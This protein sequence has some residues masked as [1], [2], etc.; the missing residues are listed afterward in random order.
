[1]RIPIAFI[2]PTSDDTLRRSQE[3]FRALVSAS[4]PIVWTT[5]AYGDVVEDIVGWAAFTGQN[6]QQMRGK[7]WHN[8]IHPGDLE[9][10]R[11]IWREALEDKTGFQSEYRL[12]RHDGVYRRIVALGVPVLESDGSIREWV[13]TC[14]DV[15]EQRRAESLKAGQARV[16]ELLATGKDLEEVLTALV[17]GIEEQST[18]VVGSVILLDPDGRHVHCKAAPHLP[19][20]YCRALEGLPIGPRAGS[21]GTAI[22]RGA[23]VVTPDVRS[24]P[25]WADYRDLAE[26]FGLRACWSQPIF[27][28]EGKVLGSFALYSQECR[29]PDDSEKYMIESAAYIAGVAIEHHQ[30]Q[31]ALRQARDMAEA[32]N[33]AKD[34]FLATISH[35]LRTPIGAVLLWSKLLRAGTMNEEQAR[36]AIDRI[37]KSAEDQSQVVNDLLD[38]SHVLHGTMAV[39]MRPIDLGEV[40]TSTA[41]AQ[42]V[43]A[44]AK[45]VSLSVSASLTPISGDAARLRQMVF[46]LVSN[47]IKFTP[48]GGRV[49]VR[50]TSGERE[51]ALLV[52]DTGEGIS[53]KYLP[54]LFSRFS[55]ADTS[56]TRRHGGLGLGLAIVKTI[57]ELH[58]GSVRAHSEGTGRGATFEVTLPLHPDG[59]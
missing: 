50:L 43:H 48:K 31:T 20:A 32:A 1:M 35:E 28:S 11:G 18:G 59:R 47:A 16:L 22:F 33:R 30:G 46:N 23:P 53:A 4:S 21:C 27:S 26:E 44:Q 2:P 13:G 55:Q 57:A 51:A 25:L 10:V 24:D 45:G 34:D 42:R 54:H 9:R 5:T 15:T 40:V 3:R 39:S 7:G 14:V 19:P 41:E 6:F 37:V 17:E 29:E 38:V 12:R 49:D 52:I 8:A 58:G 36:E 56:I